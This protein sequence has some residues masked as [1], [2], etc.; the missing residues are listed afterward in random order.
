MLMLIYADFLLL[1]SMVRK[2]FWNV[3]SVLR[4]S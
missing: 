3:H 2:L 1:M 4:R